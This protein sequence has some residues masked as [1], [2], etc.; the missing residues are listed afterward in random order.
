[1]SLVPV[2]T[3]RLIR[4][5]EVRWTGVPVPQITLRNPDRVHYDPETRLVHVDTGRELVLMP[6]DAD[7][8]DR[9]VLVKVDDPSP[10][11]SKASASAPA[12]L[13]RKKTA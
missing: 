12:P 8:V 9:M 1:V 4:P 6:L 11:S 3:L 5:I 13:V 7:S 10:S 2:A